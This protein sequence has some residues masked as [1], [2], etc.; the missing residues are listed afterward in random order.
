MC[1]VRSTIETS[2]WRE[3]DQRSKRVNASCQ[4]VMD[5]AIVKLRKKPVKLGRVAGVLLSPALL[6]G[7]ALS[8][9]YTA[10]TRGLR[11]RRE[12]RFSNSMRMNGRTIEWARFI[13]EIK[14]GHGTMIVERFS[15]KGPIRM[16]W[17][18]D[19]VYELCPYPL[20]DWLTMARDM[21]FD[22]ARDWCHERYTSATASALLVEGSKEQW[23]TIRGDNPLWFQDGIRYLEVP[24][25][26]RLPSLS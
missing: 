1:I 9:P 4:T 22:A 25:P 16:W 6:V 18:A 23:R 17:T 8:I 13:R 7:T 11:A 10:I 2:P 20:V 5:N 12:R 3:N 21:D 15:P 26:R 24:P 19:N 14:D